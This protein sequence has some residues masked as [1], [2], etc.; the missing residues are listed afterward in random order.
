ME[1]GSK[2]STERRHSCAMESEDVGD[3]QTQQSK[4]EVEEKLAMIG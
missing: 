4:A 2:Q 3:V 1:D